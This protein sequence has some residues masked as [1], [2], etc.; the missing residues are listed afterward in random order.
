MEQLKVHC[1]CGSV[2]EVS[3]ELSGKN[4]RCLQCARL[5]VV[6]KA[7]IRRAEALV[8]RAERSG[9]AFNLM[10]YLYGAAGLGVCALLF[11]FY[12]WFIKPSVKSL[13]HASQEAKRT[14]SEIRAQDL[15][16]VPPKKDRPEFEEVVS[17][18]TPQPVFRPFAQKLPDDPR[19]VIRGF[20]LEEVV[21]AEGRAHGTGAGGILYELKL[22][23]TPEELGEVLKKAG[24]PTNE[25]ELKELLAARA[26]IHE[27]QST[28]SRYY[29][30]TNG[31]FRW[32]DLERR[33]A[34]NSTH[35]ACG[36]YFFLFDKVVEQIDA[37]VVEA[38]QKLRPK[39]A[40]LRDA[41]RPPYT[42]LFEAVLAY[43]DAPTAQA[44]RQLAVEHGRLDLLDQVPIPGRK[45]LEIAQAHGWDLQLAKWSDMVTPEE[46]AELLREATKRCVEGREAFYRA[47]VRHRIEELPIDGLPADEALVGLLVGPGAP[48]DA[49]ARAYVALGAQVPRGYSKEQREGLRQAAK[50]S[51]THREALLM[52]LG[53]AERTAVIVEVDEVVE[54]AHLLSLREVPSDTRKQILGTLAKSY[55]SSDPKPEQFAARDAAMTAWRREFDALPDLA[56]G[57][58]KHR[59]KPELRAYLLEVLLPFAD[60]RAVTLLVEEHKA[61]K[62]KTA[63][64]SALVRV[65]R[66]RPKDWQAWHKENKSKFSKQL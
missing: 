47:F 19:A 32:S 40:S 41:A 43:V 22:Y 9:S 21:S 1:Q 6:R 53:G 55:A 15:I 33:S 31:R 29:P 52:L 12:T 50:A 64:E 26:R 5:H 58:R 20:R 36:A 60:E 30:G 66:Q 61:A 54:R 65:T 13:D 23:G 63:I 8:G 4:V 59:S 37:Q 48:A 25:T 46:H 62:D 44:F 24:P 2:F 42:K 45:R 27:A 38:I 10:P 7:P 49:W 16:L 11:G 57:L 39:A 3:N 51:R 18:P 35:D 17:N 56:A 34:P 28:M 14:D